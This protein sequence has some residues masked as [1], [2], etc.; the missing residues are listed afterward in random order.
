MNPGTHKVRGNIKGCIHVEANLFKVKVLQQGV[1]QV[2]HTDDNEAVALVNAQDMANLRAE[3]GNIVAIP[4]LA[5]F[6]EAAEVLPDL[7]G[8][9][10]HLPAELAGGDAVHTRGLELVQLA[11]VARQTPYNVVGY[12]ELFHFFPPSSFS[13]LL[14]ESCQISV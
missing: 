4:L 8:G 11:Q 7:G 5:E 3:L 13:I 14:K 2:A 6:A 1:T 12:L 9:Q 10:R